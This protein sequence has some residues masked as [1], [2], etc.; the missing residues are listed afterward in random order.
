MRATYGARGDID[1]DSSALQLSELSTKDGNGSEDDDEGNDK[2]ADA[3]RLM[4]MMI[5]IRR[6]HPVMVVGL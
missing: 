1:G 5:M 4:M 2:F 6:E 3:E